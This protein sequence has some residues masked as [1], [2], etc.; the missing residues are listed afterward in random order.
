MFYFKTKR[1]SF[2]VVLDVKMDQTLRCV[3]G[4]FLLNLIPH[5]L[6]QGNRPRVTTTSNWP[7]TFWTE[8]LTLRC[9]IEGGGDSE[10]TF[11]WR[12]DR[13]SSSDKYT[14]DNKYIIS[15]ATDSDNGDYECIGR[16]GSPNSTFTPWSEPFKLTVTPRTPKAELRAD[17][18]SIP[19]GGAVTLTCDVNPPSS[20]WTYILYRGDHPGTQDDGKNFN[21]RF[22]VS[23]GGVYRCRGVR[24]EPVYYTY[25]SDSVT[26]NIILSNR[27]VVTL[28]PHWTEIHSGEKITLRCEIEGGDDSE[29]EYEWETTSSDRSVKQSESFEISATSYSEGE[30]KCKGKHKTE[31]LSSTPWSTPITLT[32]SAR[33]PK[34]EL[35]AD[36]TSIPA[37]GA[38][39]LTCDVNPPS[40]GWTYILFRGDHPGTQDDGKNF[41]GR[42]SVSKGGVYWCRGERGE[43][44]YYTEYSDSVTINI[45]LSDRAVVTLQP[46]WTE[47]HSGE[48]ITLR[49]EIEGGDDSEWEYEWET[50]SSDRSVRQSESFEITATSYSEGEYKCKGKHKT[51]V[52]SSTPWSTPITLTVS[53]QKPKPE[54]KADVTDIPVGGYVTLTC[55]VSSSSG[56]Q[57]YF[58]YRADKSSNPSSINEFSSAGQKRVSKEGL[59]WCRGAR[60][61]PVYYTEDSNTIQLKENTVANKA[62]V[63]LHPNWSEIYYKESITLRCE[64]QDGDDAE[65]EYE[66]KT[67][68][69]FKPPKEKEYSIGPA[70]TS[71]SG[72]Y[73]CKGR[74]K[75]DQSPTGWSDPITLTVLSS[76]PQPVLTVSPLWLS[77]GDSVTLNCEVKHPSAG[78]RFY[79]YEAIPKL[80]DNSYNYQLLSGSRNGTEKYSFIV[81]GQ[82]HTAGYVCRAGRGEMNTPYSEPKFVWSG[83]LP[84]SASLTV[85]PERVQHFTS[86]SVSLE[87]K[88]N[89]TQWRV[90]FQ[91][92]SF[93]ADCSLWDKMTGSTCTIDRH[94][95]RNNV[96]WCESGSGEFSNAVNITKQKSDIIL[97]S[98]VHPVTEGSSVSLSCRL[99]S[100]DIVSN[101]FF[102]QNNKLIQNDTRKELNISAVSKS[103]EGFYKC[104]TSGRESSQSWMSVTVVSRL[105]NP[106]YLL[107]LMIVGLICGVVLIILLLLLY[108]C[109]QSK[110]SCLIRRSIQS[111]S[112]NQDSATNPAAQHHEYSPPLQGDACHYE[113]IKGPEDTAHDANHSQSQDVTYSL[114][115]LKNIGKKGKK[116]EPDS[117]IYSDV[118]LETEDTSVLY[119]QVSCHNP[120]KAKKNKGK[121]TPAITEESVYSEVKPDQ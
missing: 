107:I 53:E 7:E 99:R 67:S 66:W 43:P 44:V 116:P 18:T 58:W 25:Y 56:W 105:G 115:E 82:T 96:Y 52:L 78:W 2:I 75:S 94:I 31:V 40:S 97:V 33:R 109:R 95:S 74:K 15:Q 3:L 101:V 93:L 41:N 76:S 27:A 47:I 5:G 55:D 73:S 30:Y 29:W 106:S 24:G 36:R 89:S 81:N 50:T 37:G 69:S 110:D 112:T 21:G 83:D 34:A 120:G 85:S 63:T 10:W 104:Q 12:R 111:E 68:N 100:S 16:R 1:Q 61:N 28:Q 23:K 77:P 118:R 39:T 79:W 6:A 113:S 103:D 71:H 48:K 42:I 64:I 13:T 88:G 70:D 51:E 108:R 20:G 121:P 114:I 11:G 14:T 60:G 35:R 57:Y 72:N 26:I 59:Y 46:H 32:V 38:V 65:W 22:S 8:T 90:K 98:P 117:T 91:E 86:D 45:I 9:E 54:L 92:D 84:S 62:V 17:S 87:C 49:C 80:S 102:Y 19:A 119:S 4:F